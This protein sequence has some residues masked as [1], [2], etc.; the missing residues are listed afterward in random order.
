MAEPVS[1]SVDGVLPVTSFA[2]ET[3]I[4]SSGHAVRTTTAAA[5]E[6][7]MVSLPRKVPS[8]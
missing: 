6:R 2:S 1:G 4:R 7:V 5:C 8:S 3:S